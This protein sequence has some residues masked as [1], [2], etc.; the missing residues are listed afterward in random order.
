MESGMATQILRNMLAE[1]A[2]AADNERRQQAEL[3]QHQATPADERER[4]EGH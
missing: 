2:Q 4:A 3:E 1:E